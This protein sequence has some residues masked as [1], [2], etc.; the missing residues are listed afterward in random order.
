MLVQLYRDNYVGEVKEQLNYTVYDGYYDGNINSTVFNINNITTTGATNDLTSLSTMTSNTFNENDIS[1]KSVI[2][3][4]YFRAKYTG[5]YTFGVIAES[6]N[7]P[8][9]EGTGPYPQSAPI[10][11]NQALLIDATSLLIF[12]FQLENNSNGIIAEIGGSGNGSF[13]TVY[14]DGSK[15]MLQIF[16]F[17]RDVQAVVILENEQLIEITKFIGQ[18]VRLVLYLVRDTITGFWANKVVINNELIRNYNINLNENLAGSNYTSIGGFDTVPSGSINPDNVPIQYFKI[19]SNYNSAIYSHKLWYSTLP[20]N[21][22]VKANLYVNNTLLLDVNNGTY[23]FLPQTA[24]I[25]LVAGSYYLMDL[26]LGKNSNAYFSA[27][28]IEPNSSNKIS[29]A[30]GLTTYYE[31]NPQTQ[32]VETVS[33]YPL[34]I[35]DGR[36]QGLCRVSPVA[37]YFNR[38]NFSGGKHTLFYM[39]SDD[40]FNNFNGTYKNYIQLHEK[41]VA[42]DNERKRFTQF[43]SDMSFECYLNGKIEVVFRRG[44]NEPITWRYAM[45]I[46]DVERIP[47]KKI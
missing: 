23:D 32:Q 12:N 28:Y 27:Y 46:L 41:P 13:I 29:N 2:I 18:D 3:E 44:V 8:T 35:E 19:T 20:T 9:Y 24:T 7:N 4:G 1:A 42:N 36:L 34:K 26:Y 38:A 37:L 17:R 45:L 5:E 31:T 22:N 10:S 47:F 30:N 25:N 43:S 21:T 6:L 39:A 11:E 15:K 14:N 40:L 16:H 33:T